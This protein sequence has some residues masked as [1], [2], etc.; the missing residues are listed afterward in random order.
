[1]GVGVYGGKESRGKQA[2]R[3]GVAWSQRAKLELDCFLKQ[4]IYMWLD[5]IASALNCAKL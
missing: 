1:M 3:G 5:P 4:S 2:G